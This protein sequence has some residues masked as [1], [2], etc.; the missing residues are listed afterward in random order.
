M[1]TVGV[2]LDGDESRFSHMTCAFSDAH[3][4]GG[5]GGEVFTEIWIRRTA[6]RVAAPLQL[7]GF[8]GGNQNFVSGRYVLPDHQG[9]SGLALFSLRGTSLHFG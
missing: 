2:E 5:Q 4:S 1:G 3:Y 6:G 8:F 9:E 7:N